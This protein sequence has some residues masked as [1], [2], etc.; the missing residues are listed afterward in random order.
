MNDERAYD[1][2]EAQIGASLSWERI[3]NKVA[4]R[5]ALHRPSAITDSPEELGALRAWAVDAMNRFYETVATRADEVLQS[6]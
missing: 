3:S 2:I 5:S 4:S 6:V 1:E